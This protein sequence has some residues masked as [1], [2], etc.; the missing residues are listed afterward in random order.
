MTKKINPGIHFFL[1]IAFSII[2]VT[3]CKNDLHN[4]DI[5][6][7]SGGIYLAIAGFWGIIAGGVFL[8]IPCSE[9]QAKII[10]MTMIIIGILLAVYGLYMYR[11]AH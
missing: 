4:R 6:N 2:F 10:N 5:L 9:S 3:I 11:T 8:R 1:F 7:M